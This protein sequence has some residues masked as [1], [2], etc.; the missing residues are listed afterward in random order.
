VICPSCGHRNVN[1][2]A[3]FCGGC[4]KPVSA[5][6]TTPANAPASRTGFADQPGPSKV[7]QR[8]RWLTATAAILIGGTVAVAGV[9]SFTAWHR[10]R[11][12]AG[13]HETPVS[14]ASTTSAAS[15]ASVLASRGHTNSSSSGP[16]SPS[17]SAPS[18][19]PSDTASQ[20][21]AQSV[22]A[23]LQVTPSAQIPSGTNIASFDQGGEIE[24]VSQAYGGPGLKGEVLI[25]GAGKTSWQ[26]DAVENPPRSM[27]DNWSYPQEIVF[28]F[29]KHD[30]ALVSAVVLQNPPDAPGPDAV[31]IWTS[32]N[33]SS[34]DFQPVAA[35]HLAS[36][37]P[38][39]TISFAPVEARYVK[40]RLLSGP[41]DNVQLR[42]IQIIEGSQ[43]GYTSLLARHPDLLKWKKSVRYA[44]QRGVDW[45]EAAAMSW[46]EHSG[47]YGCHVQAQTM[48]GLAIA[49]TNNYLVN[50]KTLHDL[51]SFTSMKQDN[52]G[53]EME[54]DSGHQLTATHFAAMGMSYFD[55]ANGIKSDPNLRRY[56]DWMAS[57]F[58]ASGSFPIDYVNPPIAQ[59]TINSTANA[60]VAC[61]EAYAQ[62]GDAKYKGLADRG[63]NFI[64]S[65]KPETT[66][67]E[68]FQIIA[69]ARFGTATQRERAAHVI[70]QLK[71]GQNSD[72][73]WSKTSDTK[74]SDPFATGQVLYAFKEA[75]VS[76]ESPEFSKGVR[77]LIDNQ[78]PSGS[79]KGDEQSTFAPTMWA[80]IGLAGNID[81]ASADALKDELDKYGKVVLYINFDFNRATIRPDGKPIV[82][83]VV[84][85]LSDNPDLRIAINGHTDNVGTRDYN[86]KLSDKRAAAVVDAIVAAG[87]V[88]NRMTSEGFG[89]D[90]P[91]ADNAT[92][93]GRSKNR[94]VELVK[95]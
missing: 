26:P 16:A 84:K 41:P 22:T 63:L 24:S 70:E 42:Q 34:T 51:A 45:L 79:W 43:P 90:Q 58:T 11:T 2:N 32:K 8:S 59:G 12:S 38:I 92:E 56:V 62:T 31:D 66:Q 88:R 64:A 73:G 77:Y 29:Y 57:R 78:S 49:Q 83:Q 36:T 94:R 69:L 23:S 50:G 21:A 4:G 1:E 61:M 53:H 48:M 33:A 67:D 55:E 20:N 91:I 40:V 52:D 39:Q 25:D 86:V 82:A 19:S 72:G 93:K 30:S 89:P 44:A 54:D 47:C 6:A 7:A 71:A 27:N 10:S 18:G 13:S 74:A 75:G 28:S 9:I 80:V 35:A 87:I 14:S 76:P 46:Q 85:L 3:P 68:V 37:A 81:V 15:D 60:V 95:M 17:S 65:Q 5:S